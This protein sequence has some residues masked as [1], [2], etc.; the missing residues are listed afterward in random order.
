M[1]GLGEVGY[2]TC[3]RRPDLYSVQERLLRADMLKC[4]K[5]FHGKSCIQP[6]YGLRNPTQEL[7][8]I[9]SRSNTE[10]VRLM[11]DPV[12]SAKESSVIGTLC[13]SPLLVVKP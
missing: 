4:W 9:S 8:A 12:S 5:I 13:Q 2:G 11:P 10:D 7:M 1:L 6:I 3:L